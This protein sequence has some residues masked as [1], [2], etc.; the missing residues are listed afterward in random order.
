MNPY[1]KIKKRCIYYYDSKIYNKCNHIDTDKY[2]YIHYE[3]DQNSIKISKND[4]IIYAR[5]DDC[6]KNYRGIISNCFCIGCGI[7]IGNNKYYWCAENLN[8]KVKQKYCGTCFS[9]TQFLK[10]IVYIV[11]HGWTHILIVPK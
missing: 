1:K 8:T 10:H 2:V 7:Y 11:Y 9:N 3:D 4:R 5:C 6:N